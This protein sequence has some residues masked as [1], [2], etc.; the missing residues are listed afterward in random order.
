M[1]FSKE[2]GEEIGGKIVGGSGEEG[3][4]ERP[5]VFEE[6]HHFSKEVGEEEGGKIVGRS[7]EEGDL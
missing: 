6:Q 1:H 3:D 4:F 5:V 7:R 2:F